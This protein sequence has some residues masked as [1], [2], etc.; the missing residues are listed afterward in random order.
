[1]AKRVVI[2][3]G[4]IHSPAILLRSG[5][6]SMRR[7]IERNLAEHPSIWV[8]PRLARR[9]VDNEPNTP[10]IGLILRWSSGVAGCGEAD[11]QI[12]GLNKPDPDDSAVILILAAVMEPFSRGTVMLV[13]DDPRIDPRV[14]FHLLSDP[15]DAA[16]MRLAAQELFALLAHDALR[17]ITCEVT[18]ARRGSDELSAERSDPRHLAEA[19]A[20]H[21]WLRAN[22][23]DYLHACGS[24]KMGSPDDPTAVV[25]PSC[26]FIGIDNLF[27]VDAS[28]MPV[29]PRANTHL[30]AVMIAERAASFLISP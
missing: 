22:V 21:S 8:M 9:V 19:A 30:T 6:G 18:L 23:R 11:L 27:V 12:V 29:I 4:A 2:S 7:S 17:A 26:R 13:S 24:C 1:M 15:R 16:R 25:D 14:E 28:I 5:L 3:A 20:S 10:S